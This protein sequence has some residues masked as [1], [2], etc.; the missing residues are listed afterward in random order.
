VYNESSV[1]F[2]SLISVVSL[3]SI[4]ELTKNDSW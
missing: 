3:D 4:R 2:E 1:F